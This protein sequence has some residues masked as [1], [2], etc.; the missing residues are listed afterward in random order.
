MATLNDLKVMVKD[1]KE[2]TWLIEK[3]NQLIDIDTN[4]SINESAYFNG[5]IPYRMVSAICKY[6]ESVNGIYKDCGNTAVY[7]G[8]GVDSKLESGITM[9]FKRGAKKSTYT[10]V[11][12]VVCPNNW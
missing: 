12:L 6:I 2:L 7:H 11:E 8:I 3:S 10:N 5:T 4:E 1:S 9:T